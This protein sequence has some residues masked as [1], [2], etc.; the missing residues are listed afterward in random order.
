MKRTEAQVRQYVEEEIQLM[1][2]N[3][4]LNEWPSEDFKTRFRSASPEGLARTMARAGSL[5]INTRAVYSNVKDWLASKISGTERGSTPAGQAAAAAQ[6]HARLRKA[7][8]VLGTSLD[9][10]DRIFET[11]TKDIKVLEL[12]SLEELSDA[13]DYLGRGYNQVSA[14]YRALY[15]QYEEFENQRKGI[16]S[17]EDVLGPEATTP[18]MIELPSGER[19]KN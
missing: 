4:E 14:I 15:A 10:L 3:G 9:R 6:Q 18:E 13:L 2:E 19:E 17:D 16:P 11:L 7:T 5:G 12:D 1:L 8:I